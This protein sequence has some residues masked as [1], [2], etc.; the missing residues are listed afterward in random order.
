MKKKIIILF[1][2][3]III[4]LLVFFIK[5]LY[6]VYKSNLIDIIKNKDNDNND[7]NKIVN[8]NYL[9]MT[10][11]DFKKLNIYNR[12]MYRSECLKKFNEFKFEYNFMLHS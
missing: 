11:L 7:N 8:L 4:L 6:N 1:I 10:E 2:C 5:Y 12:W 9:T 3:L